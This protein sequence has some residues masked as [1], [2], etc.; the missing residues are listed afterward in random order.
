M[1]AWAMSIHK[2]QGQTLERVRV[3]CGKIFENG[4]GVLG[5][6]GHKEMFSL[7]FRSSICSTVSCN[8]HA[9]I[10]SAPLQP[11]E[12]CSLFFQLK[13]RTEL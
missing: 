8:Q 9:I 5:F 7:N 10:A 11:S 6:R 13:Y 3:D 4:Q 12:V 2:S 1:L